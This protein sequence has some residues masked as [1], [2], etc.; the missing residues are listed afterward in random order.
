M[1]R[2]LRGGRPPSEPILVPPVAVVQRQSSDLLAVA[3]PHLAAALRYVREHV[4][5]PL[6]VEKVARQVPLSRRV[7]ERRFREHLGRTV[8][9]EIHRA[10]IERI[11]QLL[12][13]TDQTTEEIAEHCGFAQ[14]S[15]MAAFFRKKTGFA[16]GAFRKQFRHKASG[17]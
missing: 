7:L 15:H 13:A 3:D 16:P 14:L 8:L 2:L 10:K 12:I 5:Q 9:S 1:A 17:S 6:T 11:K 4:D